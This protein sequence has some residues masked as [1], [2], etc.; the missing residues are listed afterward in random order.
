MADFGMDGAFLICPRCLR[1][2]SAP[3]PVA[4]E[5]I[6]RLQNVYEHVN[7]LDQLAVWL[8]GLFNPASY[9]TA[10]RRVAAHAHSVSV[11]ELALQV[12]ISL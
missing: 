1:F 2:N 11:E 12:C 4:G 9:V 5:R 3:N 7:K 8:G 6:K 10:T